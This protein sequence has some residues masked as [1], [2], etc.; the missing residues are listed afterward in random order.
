MN[1]L[2]HRVEELELDGEDLRR[3]VDKL[4]KDVERCEANL[5][6]VDELVE[7]DDFERLEFRVDNL[8]G[9]DF[10]DP[11]E[12]DALVR[13]VRELEKLDWRAWLEKKGTGAPNADPETTVLIDP[14]DRRTLP[15]WRKVVPEK[16]DRVVCVDREKFL[17]VVRAASA[18]A[19]EKR[20]VSLRFD[21]TGL[22]ATCVGAEIGTSEV[23]EP[24]DSG[25][26]DGLSLDVDPENLRF[27][28]SW[29]A[30]SVEISSSDP[31]KPFRVA[32]PDGRELA[33]VMPLT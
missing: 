16:G 8:E 18:T 4:A 20:R 14:D 24:F 25:N 27:L 26:V 31:V 22:T 13:R 3:Q 33:A 1:D 21:A 29:N 15:D 32:S 2:K 28:E 17:R 9:D 7:R 19:D 23:V 5:P 11:D 6:D 30:P 10:V 12:F